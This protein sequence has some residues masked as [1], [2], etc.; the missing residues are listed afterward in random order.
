M[1]SDYLSHRKIVLRLETCGHEQLTDLA[2]RVGLLWGLGLCWGWRRRDR[3]G[4]GVFSS[5]V[6][7]ESDVQ[8]D[9]WVTVRWADGMWIM[10]LWLTGLFHRAPERFISSMNLSYSFET[11]A[12]A[13]VSALTLGIG[14]RAIAGCGTGC[15]RIAASRVAVVLAEPGCAGRRCT[16]RAIGT[17]ERSRA[18]SSCASSSSS[19]SSGE[20]GYGAMT[21]L[22]LSSSMASDGTLSWY[23]GGVGGGG[24]GAF[25]L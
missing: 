3:L 24:S 19:C 11:E 20:V 18:L 17:S 14:T 10:F 8:R 22:L 6:H 5:L 1:K 7:W 12:S 2:E 21:L 4:I 25:A 9:L 23:S 13:V 15:S 16:R